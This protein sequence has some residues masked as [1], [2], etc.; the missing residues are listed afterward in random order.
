MLAAGTSRSGS[1]PAVLPVNDFWMVRLDDATVTVVSVSQAGS[2]LAAGQLLPGPVTTTT[3]GRCVAPTGNVSSRVTEKVRV[4]VAPAA[5]SIVQVRVSLAKPQLL[6][7]S[8]L[9]VAWAR[10]AE[11]SSETGTS[12][13][14]ALPLLWTVI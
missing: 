8:A 1:V 5:T 2:W 7:Q 9:Y 4:T 12:F 6:L 11:M 10:I 14:S 3:F 13:A